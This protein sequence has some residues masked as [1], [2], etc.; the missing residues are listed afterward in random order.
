MKV[1]ETM[2]KATVIATLF[3]SFSLRRRVFEFGDGPGVSLP[4]ALTVPHHAGGIIAPRKH[5]LTN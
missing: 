1:F 5:L 3:T 4:A 2:S